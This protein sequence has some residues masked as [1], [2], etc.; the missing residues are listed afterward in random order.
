MK[1]GVAF[2]WILFLFATAVILI[3]YVAVFRSSKKTELPSFSKIIGNLFKKQ[4]QKRKKKKNLDTTKD[5]KEVEE[6]RKVRDM[7][8]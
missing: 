2:S 3:F 5:S 4:V 1:K 7:I 6:I 8:K